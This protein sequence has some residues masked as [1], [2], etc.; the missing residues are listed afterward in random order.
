MREIL[1]IVNEKTV[2][3]VAIFTLWDGVPHLYWLWRT[4]E[5]TDLHALNNFSFLT[6]KVSFKRNSMS[7][8][9][10]YFWRR[11]CSPDVYAYAHT[12]E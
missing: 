5:Q 12:T 8:G 7:L 1:E 6:D 4:G 10:L 3:S 2:I 9:L 11:S